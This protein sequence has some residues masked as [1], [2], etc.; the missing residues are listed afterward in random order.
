MPNFGI[1]LKALKYAP[2]VIGAVQQ[3]RGQQSAHT[4]EELTETRHTIEDLR[5]E[6]TRRF[7]TLENDNARLK[8]RLRE[9]ESAVMMMK[10]LVM[11]GGV[12]AVVAFG[13]AILALL[14]HHA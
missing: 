11:C 6:M 7:E 2:M 12:F 10:I 1:I 5:K 3:F 8:T 4:E 14:I 9:A 13:L